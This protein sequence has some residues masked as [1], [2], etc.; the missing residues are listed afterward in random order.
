M[1]GNDAAVNL[2]KTLHVYSLLH[3]KNSLNPFSS[4]MGAAVKGY[5]RSAGHRKQTANRQRYRTI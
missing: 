3:Y 2:D 1:E 5:E 4:A